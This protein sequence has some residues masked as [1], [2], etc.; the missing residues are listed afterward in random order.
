M[1]IYFMGLMY[2][3]IRISFNRNLKPKIP[4]R[5]NFNIKRFKHEK[6]ENYI[7]RTKQTPFDEL[8][9]HER[10]SRNRLFRYIFNKKT[11]SIFIAILVVPAIA[12]AVYRYRPQFYGIE[13]GTNKLSKEE[14]G[15]DFGK[16]NKNGK[17]RSYEEKYSNL[18]ERMKNE[19]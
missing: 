10:F 14:F 8:D 4:N 6:E 17:K 7:Y 1:G 18:M 11:T 15:F 2:K 12:D 3:I 13:F 5:F 9:I 16:Q 19:K